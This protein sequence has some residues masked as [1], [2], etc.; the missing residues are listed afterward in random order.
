MF[1]VGPST[2][3]FDVQFFNVEEDSWLANFDRKFFDIMAYASRVA[4]DLG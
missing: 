3:L 2:L 1:K 4:F